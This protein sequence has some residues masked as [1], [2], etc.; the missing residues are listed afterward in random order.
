MMILPA[1]GDLGEFQ[2]LRRIRRLK[3]MRL[4]QNLAGMAVATSL[5][6]MLG[7]GCASSPSTIQ[8]PAPTAYTR[9]TAGTTSELSPVAPGEGRNVR[10]VGDHWLCE[11]NGKTMVYNNATQS[12]EPQQK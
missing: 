3:E 11:V 7:S 9:S 12:W 1:K 5:L 6:I 8:Q 4:K 2:R 10:K